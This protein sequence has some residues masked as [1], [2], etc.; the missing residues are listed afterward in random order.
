MSKDIKQDI[1]KKTL[2]LS[3]FISTLG[4][5]VGISL[6]TPKKKE[7]FNPYSAEN[8]SQVQEL[9][10]VMSSYKDKTSAQAVIVPNSV[11][12]TKSGKTLKFEFEK[13]IK[14]D[15]FD[16][17]VDHKGYRNITLDQ[18]SKIIEINK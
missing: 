11:D 15:V 3:G 14:A 17:I 4:S 10:N 1:T 6:S 9:Y 7:K 5:N 18:T 2:G 12:A 8:Q 13:E 16:E